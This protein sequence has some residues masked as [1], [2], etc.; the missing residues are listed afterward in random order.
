MTFIQMHRLPVCLHRWFSRLVR[1]L[2]DYGFVLIRQRSMSSLQSAPS[3]GS[4]HLRQVQISDV[5]TSLVVGPLLSAFHIRLSSSSPAPSVLG[6]LL[7]TFLYFPPS[8]TVLSNESHR[9]RSILFVSFLLRVSGLFLLQSLPALVHL[10]LCSVQQ[11][12]SN[13]LQ[14]N[15][16]K[17]ILQSFYIHFSRCTCL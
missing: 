8:M 1:G 14:G 2:L 17:P 12:F 3:S 13:L 16:S 10:L 5:A 15:I 11:I 9:V 4:L 7:F 6:F